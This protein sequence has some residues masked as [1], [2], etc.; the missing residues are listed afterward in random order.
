[1]YLI[2]SFFSIYF[3]NVACIKIIIFFM[4]FV[5]FIF[6]ERVSSY[7]LTNNFCCNR[8]KLTKIYTGVCL[9]FFAGKA[10]PFSHYQESG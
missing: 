10:Q 5:N 2:P 8:C 6:G 9:H 4:P 3:F 1:M 7:L